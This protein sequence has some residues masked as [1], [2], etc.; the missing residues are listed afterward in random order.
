MCFAFLSLSHTLISFTSLFGLLSF[1]SRFFAS[2]ASDPSCNL[3]L[4]SFLCS[5]TL[6]TISLFNHIPLVPP[7]LL[8]TRLPSR[9]CRAYRSYSFF[10]LSLSTGHTYT[11]LQQVLISC[12]SSSTPFFDL[13]PS[14]FPTPPGVHQQ[15]N[16]NLPPLVQSHLPC[17]RF[18]HNDKFIASLCTR[19]LCCERH[20][21]CF[22]F[23]RSN[24]FNTSKIICLCQSIDQ[25]N[26]KFSHLTNGVISLIQVFADMSSYWAK[27]PEPYNDDSTSH[28]RCNVGCFVALF[29]SS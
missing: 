4:S 9:R 28:R 17:L 3:F 11:R 8:S 2:L 22:P 21:F 13:S 6:P 19:S 20:C 25:S 12:T 27:C 29:S 24:D 26:K 16:K 18:S 10:S 7:P 23:S 5:S 15:P 14:V 1:F